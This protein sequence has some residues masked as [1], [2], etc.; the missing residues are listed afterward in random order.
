MATNCSV[1]N[2]ADGVHQE[3]MLL[4]PLQGMADQTDVGMEKE[5]HGRMTS[6]DCRV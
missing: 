2:M 3:R 5:D 4:E 1:C 6:I